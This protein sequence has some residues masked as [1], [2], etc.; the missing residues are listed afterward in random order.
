MCQPHQKYQCFITSTPMGQIFL[1]ITANWK[2]DARSEGGIAECLFD[3]A[4][5]VRHSIEFIQFTSYTRAQ[6]KAF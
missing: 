4:L 2:F 5:S 3:T 1:K 6:V